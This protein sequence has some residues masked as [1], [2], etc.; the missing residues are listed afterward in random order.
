MRH[1]W[2]IHLVH[3]L[4]DFIRPHRRADHHTKLQNRAHDDYT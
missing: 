1:L 3:Q 4:L 2:L